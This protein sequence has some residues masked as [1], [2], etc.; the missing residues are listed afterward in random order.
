[1][2]V[3]QVVDDIVRCTGDKGVFAVEL[4]FQA[5]LVLKQEGIG[6]YKILGGY[7]GYSLIQKIL[8]LVTGRAVF[9]IGIQLRTCGPLPSVRTGDSAVVHEPVP[10]III[11]YNGIHTVIYRFTNLPVFFYPD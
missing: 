11:E 7:L 5:F 10:V 4:F 8:S 6:Y 3:P 9:V 1:M 2:F